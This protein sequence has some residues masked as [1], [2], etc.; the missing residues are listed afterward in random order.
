[1]QLEQYRKLRKLSRRAAAIELKCAENTLYRWEKGRQ[2]PRPKDLKK[3]RE[4]SG[5]AVTA[6]DFFELLEGKA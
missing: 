1:M 5:G 6:N 2:T 4:W 3:I